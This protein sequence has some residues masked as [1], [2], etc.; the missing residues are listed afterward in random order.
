[1]KIKLNTNKIPLGNH[2]V[3]TSFM[4]NDQVYIKTNTR[5]NHL[6]LCTNL[7]TGELTALHEGD[8]VEELHGVFNYER[9]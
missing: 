1:M 7:E 5:K 4:Y 9:K 8:I 2:L 3:G 6:C